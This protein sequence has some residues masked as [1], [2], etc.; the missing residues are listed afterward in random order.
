MLVNDILVKMSLNPLPFSVILPTGS[1][2]AV[3]HRLRSFFILSNIYVYVSLGN[4]QETMYIDSANQV[5]CYT[6]TECMRK[7]I[8]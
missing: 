6:F 3:W 5:S 2:G 4:V 8:K 1:N 7:V